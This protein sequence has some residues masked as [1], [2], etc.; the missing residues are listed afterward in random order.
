MK[1]LNFVKMLLLCVITLSMTSCG[2]DNYYVMQNSDDK[3]CGKTW[4]EASEDE[5]DFTGINYYQLKFDKNNSAQ[6]IK[7][8]YRDGESEPYK[9]D[10]RRFT[11]KWMDDTK[12]TL[13]LDFGAKETIYFEN[14]W[15]RE[16]YLSGKLDGKMIVLTDLTMLIK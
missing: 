9:R 13:I 16:H 8:Y 15:V 5:Y 7:E 4:T 3:L 2:D 12:E 11:W 10:T 6:E 14:V 1:T